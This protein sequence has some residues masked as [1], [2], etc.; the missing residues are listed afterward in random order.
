MHLNEALGVPEVERKSSV[1]SKF[2]CGRTLGQASEC[3]VREQRLPSLSDLCPS[4]PVLQTTPLTPN[5]DL[6]FHIY[7]VSSARD[8]RF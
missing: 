1:E 5:G 2:A 7:E 4:N 8:W 6:S 3:L